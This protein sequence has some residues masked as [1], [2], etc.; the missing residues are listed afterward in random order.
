M[1]ILNSGNRRKGSAIRCD[2]ETH[3]PKG[4]STFSPKIVAQIGRLPDQLEDR[5][6]VID[7]ER[8]AGD[9]E[10][11]IK[12]LEFEEASILPLAR[13]SKRWAIDEG[14]NVSPVFISLPSAKAVDKWAPLLGL[15]QR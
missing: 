7:L 14:K 3:D 8:Q 12:L 9:E 2:S 13:K 6:I 11:T 1:E 5:S 4:F 15:A 10:A